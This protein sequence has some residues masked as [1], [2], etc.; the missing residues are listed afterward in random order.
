MT[1]YR[2]VLAVPGLASLLGVSLLARTAITADVMALTMY[3]VLGLGMSY[4]A[5][6][7]VAAALTA[8]VA[9]G[10]PLL[11]GMI[12]RRGLRAVLLVTIGAQVVFWLSVPAL[13][14]GLLL[15]AAF[16]AGLLMVPAQPVTRQAIAAMTTAGQRRAAFALESVQGELSYIV[17]P[18]IVILCAAN[19]SPG[20]VA[21]G[22]GAAIVV[23]GAGI[24]LLDPPL[25][26]A[27]EAGAGA[28]GRPPRREWLGSGMIAV[29]TMAFGTTMLLGGIDLAIV[30]ALEEAGQVSWAAAVVTVL[31]VT[32]VIGGLVYGALSRSLPTWLLLGLLGLLTVP[33]GLAHDWRW[34]CVA[35]VGSGLLTAP[36]LSTLADAVSRLAPASVRGEATGLQSSAL[37]AGFALGAPVAGIAIDASAPAGG[38]AAAGLAGVA[39]ALT[40]L[41]LSRRSPARTRSPLGGPG[42]AGAPGPEPRGAD[43][44]PGVSP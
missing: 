3:V 19:L 29:L 4:T 21:W 35:V 34:L 17:G 42:L 24:A 44:R 33:A 16:A 15:G 37:S 1:G 23:G 39:A 6:G 43:A 38:F 11:G 8:G 27:D 28:A 31:G 13:P 9:L 41:L 7:G 5:A 30:A 10:G 18:A 32:S 40:G 26:A 22:V 14:Y 25:R 12:D 20:V 2:Q 36:T